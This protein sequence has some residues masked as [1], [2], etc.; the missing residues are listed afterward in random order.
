M[1][2]SGVSV[3]LLLFLRMGLMEGV[4]ALG[5]TGR[6]RLASR[7]RLARVG[8][9]GRVVSGQVWTGSDSGLVVL[10]VTGTAG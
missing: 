5:G 3:L 8:Q 6:T 9:S 4:V 10:V 7:I 1:R 2:R